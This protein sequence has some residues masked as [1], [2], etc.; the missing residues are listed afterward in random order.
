LN[1]FYHAPGEGRIGPLSA[2]ELRRRYKERR[3]QRDT[4]VWR[5]GLQEWQPLERVGDEI[6][7]FSVTPDASMPPPLPAA[8]PMSMAPAAVGHGV[9]GPTPMYGAGAARMQPAPKR[10]SGCLIALIVAAVL[11]I[12]TVGILAAIALPSYDTY[13]KRSKVAGHVEPRA[14]ALREGTARALATLDRCPAEP[15]EAGLDAA[16]ATG[17]RVGEVDGRCAFE[18]SLAGV[19]PA[20]DGK[21]ILYVAPAGTDDA[22]DCT[23]GDLPRAFRSAA[24]RGTAP[25]TETP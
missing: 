9:R 20:V 7:L 10:M 18:I 6:D 2:D 14:A 24:C 15:L 5:E 22:W 23:G 21:T 17:V 19:D 25:D 16:A 13:V 1:W 3:I 11:A 4:L 8:M 12:P